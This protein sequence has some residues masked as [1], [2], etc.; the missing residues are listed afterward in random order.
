M[1]FF[2][3]TNIDLWLLGGVIF[4]IDWIFYK[5]WQHDKERLLGRVQEL[6]ENEVDLYSQ[7]RSLRNKLKHKKVK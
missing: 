3:I 1:T 7:I 6:E 5:A 2:E 4:C